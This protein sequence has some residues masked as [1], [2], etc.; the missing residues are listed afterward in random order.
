MQPKFCDYLQDLGVNISRGIS[1]MMRF[2]QVVLL[3]CLA[4]VSWAQGAVALDFESLVSPQKND[5]YHCVTAIGMASTE[6][7]TQAF[8]RQM[9][10]RD[11]L[12]NASMKNNLRVS[13]SQE[14]TNYKLTKA[15]GRFTTQS[16]VV[17]YHIIREGLQDLNEIERYDLYGVEIKGA[18]EKALATYVVEIEACLTED[19][20]ACDQILGNHY[21]LRLAVAQV[22]MDANK[23]QSVADIA[24]FLEGYH[25]EL[26]RRL[27]GSGYRNLIK[28][29]RGAA[30]FPH[31]AITPNVSPAILQPIRDET[32]AQY[33]L[34]TVINSASRHND[35]SN[36]KNNFKRFYHHEIKPN[37]RYIE[38]DWYLIDLMNYKVSHRQ[39][40]G[41]DVRGDVTVGRDKPFG[42]NAFFSTDT[43]MVFHA[44][45]T[46]QVRSVMAELSCKPLETQII[47]I[48]DGDYIVYLSADSGA[49]VGDTLAVY[50]KFGRNVQFQGVD[51]GMDSE[52]VGFLT[53]K[54][55]HS[56]FAVAELAGKR[57]V[58]AVGDT[59][60]SW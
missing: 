14:V 15:V 57:G 53:I 17:K 13:V 58:I 46:K 56:K 28:M 7:V 10:I 26:Y 40:I 41:F 54:R 35:D 2:F 18:V 39:R 11:A 45:L 9:A 31:Q 6:G 52:P 1:I 38:I 34:L 49:Q 8:A 33:L 19:P 4:S 12:K 48:R 43:G 32:G 47:D 27:I 3:S 44:L 5:S 29:D 25:A 20:K 37:A 24:N 55:I 59:V 51:L 50:H 23:A 36:L 22:A 30:L 21:Q 42:S 16:K 60:K